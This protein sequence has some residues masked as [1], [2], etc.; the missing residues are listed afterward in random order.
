MID[1]IRYIRSSVNMSQQEFADDLRVAFAT[2]NRW[3]NGKTTPPPAAQK[4]M[5]EF[6]FHHN[7]D[8]ADYIIRA[9]IQE[10]IK[11]EKTLDTEILFHGSKSGLEGEIMPRSRPQ[12]DFG[13]G[14]YMGTEVLQPL[15]L[16]CN[17]DNPVLY[18]VSVDRTN[19]DILELP[20]DI[21]WAFVVAYNRGRLERVNGTNI[22]KK[23]A[24]HLRNRDL[25]VG[26][27]AADRMFYVL[28]NFFE[29]NIT[30]KGLVECLSTLHLGKQYVA[31]SLKACQ[32]VKIVKEYKLSELELMA[33]KD[34]SERNR[35]T[36]IVQANKIC[37][38]YRRDGK[39][40]DEL[41]EDN[42]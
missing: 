14:F 37:K 20:T 42:E 19:L 39:F 25:I 2:V 5:F 34:I 8:I 3:E 12:C 18:F 7:I 17:Y 21:S 38:Q 1:L 26:D 9:L 28:D 10:K 6:C 23:Y 16:I 36:G 24:D 15:T 4:A 11:L 32:K 41:L 35:Q 30:D 13:R 27:I 33:L 22:Y 40:F 31:V 29:G